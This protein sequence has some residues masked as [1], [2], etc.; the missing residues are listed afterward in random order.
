MKIFNL[1]LILFLAL[2]ACKKEEFISCSEYDQLVGTWKNINGD[3]AMEIQFYSNG[4]IS[5]KTE[6]ER[7]EKRI[8][9]FCSYQDTL[10]VFSTNEENETS[11]Y[12][13]TNKNI[14]TISTFMGTYNVVDSTIFQAV[15]FI[16]K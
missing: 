1:L 5:K 14:D 13:K 12:F 9:N 7:S 8:F 11:W 2:Q 16:R 10:F 15:K 3:I 6:I 4:K